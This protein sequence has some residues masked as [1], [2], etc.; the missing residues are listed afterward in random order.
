MTNPNRTESK[1]KQKPKSKKQKATSENKLE[2]D[3]K[4]SLARSSKRKQKVNARSKA[5]AEKQF[6][7]YSQFKF[8]YTLASEKTNTILRPNPHLP[9]YRH[10]SGRNGCWA[11][12]STAPREKKLRSGA[13]LLFSMWIT[14]VKSVT[15]YT[16]ISKYLRNISKGQ[17]PLWRLFYFMIP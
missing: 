2:K 14:V 6:N 4:R 13:E 3:K 12:G 15:S 16:H 17:K 11:A 5:K 1:W 7:G 8:K 9:R 10:C